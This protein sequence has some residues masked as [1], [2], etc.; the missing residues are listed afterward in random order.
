[1]DSRLEKS[2]D[3]SESS[4]ENEAA[5]AMNGETLAEYPQEVTSFAFV[6]QSKSNEARNYSDS[7]PFDAM[8]FSFH[9]VNEFFQNRATLRMLEFLCREPLILDTFFHP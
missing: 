7:Y 9:L 5:K 3:V 2:L 1:M 8:L 4:E 6:N